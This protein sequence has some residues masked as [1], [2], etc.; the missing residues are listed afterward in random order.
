MERVRGIGGVFFKAQDP[1]ALG[2]WYQKNLGVSLSEWGGAQFR[3]KDDDHDGNAITAWNIFPAGSDYF[4]RPFMVN[5]RVKSLDRMLEQLRAAGATVDE[6][7]D[8]SE[9]GNF[10]WVTDPEGNRVEL[11][12]PPHVEGGPAPTPPAGTDSEATVDARPSGPKKKKP[13]AKKKPAK[14]KTVK[15]RRK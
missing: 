4:A 10:G 6:K 15:K 7:I 13:V 1:K 8:R 14:K 11:W 5:F 3:W 12:E 2:A 9:Y